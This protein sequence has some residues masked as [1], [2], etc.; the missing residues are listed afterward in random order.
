MCIWRGLCASSVTNTVLYS[1]HQ[2]N[3][4][5]TTKEEMIMQ[6]TMN[7]RG[8][9]RYSYDTTRPTALIA[10][11]RR[12]VSFFKAALATKKTNEHGLSNAMEARLYL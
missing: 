6:T 12:M 7:Y 2:K 8:V 9:T 11:F 5:D 4:S 1:S 3:D 10:F